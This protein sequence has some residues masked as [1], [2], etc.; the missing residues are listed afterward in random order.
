MNKK[1]MSK[2]DEPSCACNCHEGTNYRRG[3][4]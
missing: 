4:I 1:S 2:C 3:R